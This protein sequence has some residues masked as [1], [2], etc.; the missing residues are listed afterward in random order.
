MINLQFRYYITRKQSRHQSTGSVVAFPYPDDG[1]G[2][3]YIPESREKK[4]AN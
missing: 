3:G 2:C 4:K 1:C